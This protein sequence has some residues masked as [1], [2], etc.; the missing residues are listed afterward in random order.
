MRCTVNHTEF[1]EFCKEIAG[2]NHKDIVKTSTVLLQYLSSDS[3]KEAK[4]HSDDYFLHQVAEIPFVPTQ[5]HPEVTWISSAKCGS[6]NIVMN[7]RMCSLAKLSEA[8]ITNCTPF[9]W[10][11]KPIV[12]LLENWSPLTYSE[13]RLLADR[14]GI[15][16]DPTV[17][18]VIKNM[19]NISAKKRFSNFQ[20]FDQYPDS[21][22]PTYDQAMSLMSVIVQNLTLLET[23]QDDVND[24]HIQLLRDM[25]CIPVY[26][27]FEKTHK[28]HIVLVKPCSVLH[29]SAFSTDKYHPFLQILD[30][31][32]E[33]LKFILQQIGVESSIG[34]NHIQLVLQKAYEL[35]A[36]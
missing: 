19:Q 28:H 3:A 10:T 21:N 29:Y 4:W 24:A 2:G 36:G 9:L 6:N 17:D 5:I 14:L 7:R 31:Q 8:A 11:V 1:L 23:K 25:H 27:T 15:T 32:L 18:H 35:S 12:N 26:S 34:Y 20:N 30:S 33:C 16:C 13:H 22:I